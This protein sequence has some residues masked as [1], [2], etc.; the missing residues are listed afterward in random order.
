MMKTRRK[1]S[2]PG[3]PGVVFIDDFDL[4][5]AM[6]LMGGLSL[7]KKSSAE[8]RNNIESVVGSIARLGRAAGRVPCT[9]LPAARVDV[10]IPVELRQNLGVR[11]S[12]GHLS[13]NSVC[14]H[15]Q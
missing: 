4:I 1:T 14:S 6:C 11:I 12:L 3:R 10:V 15:V 2:M 7:T 9:V 13:P 5:T 8:L